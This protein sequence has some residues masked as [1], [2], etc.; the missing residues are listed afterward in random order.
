VNYAGSFVRVLDTF[1]SV[2]DVVTAFTSAGFTATALD[3]IRQVTAASLRDFI[4]TLRREAH[5]P[6]HLSTDTEYEVGLARLRDA[7]ETETGPVV[8][9]LDLLVLR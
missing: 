7:A 6:L 3:A 9:A 1:P 4:R 2:A 8:D 5:T